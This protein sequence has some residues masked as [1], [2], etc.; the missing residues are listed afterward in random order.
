MDDALFERILVPLADPDDAERTARALRP[1]LDAGSELVITHVAEG[2]GPETSI[3]RGRDHFAEDTYE[4]FIG[5]LD[6]PGVRLEWVTLQGR[7]VAEAVI[8]GTAAVDATLIAFV[9]RGLDGWAR[10]VSGD[11]GRRLIRDAHVPVLVFPDRAETL[12]IE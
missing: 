2:D 3:A 5:V 10:L 8:D 4:T 12:G 9:P 11:A 7:A 6:S 1:H